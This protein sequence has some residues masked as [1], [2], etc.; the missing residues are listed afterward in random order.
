MNWPLDPAPV[1]RFRNK[2]ESILVAPAMPFG[3]AEPTRCQNPIETVVAV[4]L[5][6]AQSAALTLQ[7]QSLRE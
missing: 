7:V 2:V 5:K 1:V 4:T 3:T 6:L